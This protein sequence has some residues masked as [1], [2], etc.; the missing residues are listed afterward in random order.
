MT[1][2]RIFSRAAVATAVLGAVMLTGE[3][4]AG[5]LCVSCLEPQATYRCQIEGTDPAGPTPAGAQVLCIKELATRGGHASCS[6]SRSGAAETCAG[7]LVVV[8]KPDGHP[9]ADAPPAGTSAP[10]EGTAG[11]A[12][13]AASEP[14]PKAPPA[15]V[16]A[17]AK[18]AAAQSKRDWDKTTSAVADTTKAAGEGLKEG[19][20]KAGDS[21]GS[22]LKKSWNCVVSLFSAC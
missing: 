13:P 19:V 4:A 18:E 3:A 9:L 21:V 12:A 2:T 5:E 8:A 6:L 17:L 15:T 1:G 7:T 11:A 16:E 10:G 20:T 22:A 14:A